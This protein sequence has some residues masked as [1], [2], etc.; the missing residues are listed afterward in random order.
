MFDKIE[1]FNFTYKTNTFINSVIDDLSLRLP[2]MFE[3]TDQDTDLGD[4]LTHVL[5]FISLHLSHQSEE[6]SVEKLQKMFDKCSFIGRKIMINLSQ[7]E[8]KLI[9]VLKF[10]A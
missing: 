8:Y 4:T 5:I 7:N 3:L 6:E 9:T 2:R 1:S 10:F